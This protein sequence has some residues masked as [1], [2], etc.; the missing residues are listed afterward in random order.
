MARRQTSTSGRNIVRTVD[1]RRIE[2]KTR[3]AFLALDYPGIASS[4]Y[5]QFTDP[6]V[7]RGNVL[8]AYLQPGLGG[9]PLRAGTPVTVQISHG[10]LRI[11]G[12]P[13]ASGTSGGA[14]P[15]AATAA[16]LAT[17]ASSVGVAGVEPLTELPDLPDDDY[18]PGI[19]VGLTTDGR[20][21][22]NVDDDW[23]AEAPAFD[24]TDFETKV[25]SSGGI[26]TF[27]L[28][29]D[30]PELPDDQY[31]EGT[32]VYVTEN[33][34][35][36]RV[37]AEGD[38]WID[39]APSVGDPITGQIILEGNTDPN[40]GNV[41]AQPFLYSEWKRLVRNGD[42]HDA[43]PDSDS[44][45]N[46]TD[47][48]LPGWKVGGT[49]TDM[50]VWWIAD[51]TTGSGGRVDIV[52]GAAPT[53][54]IYLYQPVALR[55]TST[56]NNAY[57]LVSSAAPSTISH[58][59]EYQQSL[60]EIDSTG[61]YTTLTDYT[62]TFSST[63]M[64][65][66]TRRALSGVRADTGSVEVRVGTQ[67]AFAG[68]T[69]SIGEVQLI[70]GTPVSVFPDLATPDNPPGVMQKSAGTLFAYPSFDLLPTN[71]L[72]L[73][74]GEGVAGADY[75][76]LSGTQIYL[77]GKVLAQY[78]LLLP[79]STLSPDST[80]DGAIVWNPTT[81][82]LTIGDGASAIPFLSSAGVAAAYQP[83][84]SDLTTIAGLTA[85]TDNVMQAKAGAW[86]S[87]TLAQLIADLAALGTTFQPLDADLTAIAAL[88]T[89]A[90]GRALLILANQ[91]ALQTA[92]GI[93]AVGLSGSASDLTTGTL[94]I[95]RI[96]AGDITLAKL[97]DLAQDQFIGRTTASTGVPQTATITAAARTVLDDT[98]VDAMI[99]TLGG[100]AASGSGAL[101]RKTNAALVTPALGTPSALVLT[102]ATG[103]PS[104]IGLANGTGLP[105]SG[106][107]NLTTDLAAKAATGAVGS[108]GLTMAT[109]KVLGRSTAS[110]GAIEE[111]AT[112]G[113]GSVVQATSP[114]LVTPALGTPSAAVLTNATGLPTAGLVAGAVT[115]AKMD[116]LAQ[117]QFIGRTTASTG[118]PQTATITAAARTVLDDTTVAAMRATLQ[119]AYVTD[120]AQ[121]G[122]ATAS[123][124]TV[125]VINRILGRK[126]A[127]AGS[128]AI[129]E[130]SAADMKTMLGYYTSGDSPTFTGTNI[131]GIPESGV[132]SLVSDLAAKSAVGHGAADHTDITRAIWL[133]PKD[134]TLDS[135]T[136]A[137]L[138]ATPD[139]VQVISLADGSTQGCYWTMGTPSDWTSGNFSAQVFW[140]AGT[141]DA[142]S[143]AVRWTLNAKVVAAGGT[144]VTA[145]GTSTPWTGNSG[146]RTINLTANE[147][148]Q[149]TGVAPAAATD[150]LMLNLRRIGA[151][152]ADTYLG[153]VHVFAVRVTYTANQ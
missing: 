12:L 107:T 89:T 86:S 35:H 10:Q 38:D 125:S 129:E 87:R 134:A 148:A 54:S 37:N 2:P 120:V 64:R 81:N 30:L 58:A 135:G 153:T 140:I 139:L 111:L 21:Y 138:G 115:L 114:T 15:N 76:G 26:A 67:T 72:Q 110:T 108:S 55:S 96:A 31:P 80:S 42:F 49:Y 40:L 143:H 124:L 41:G 127:G 32:T 103:T 25:T 102:N 61:A 121:A 45:I 56:R 6:T 44:P 65:D 128:F 100:A 59:N 53:G 43:P 77:I 47:N 4:A 137:T 7:V 146:A 69:I 93:A 94:P 90:Y 18:P 112:T 70:E 51:A 48:V 123:G 24:I 8:L 3:Q 145:A 126:T 39:Y 149:D 79:L 82:A 122:L 68:L 57:V 91:A 29:T 20:N 144:D 62:I 5:V 22:R 33:Q 113:S 50:E 99:D 78:G 14:G 46:N 97:A 63:S 75:A 98:T 132:T 34:H 17:T 106:V 133:Y 88:A 151:N 116:D 152:A 119:L 11:V 117:D 85:T 150:R 36:Y 71:Y 130:L 118:V 131:T 147:T 52:E 19:V 142:V 95:A 105:E 84:D 9:A 73:Y 83:L 28:V 141:T 13:G 27:A 104:S 66:F 1:R 60:L 23:S 101:V 136:L 16:S 92:V 109:N 74:D